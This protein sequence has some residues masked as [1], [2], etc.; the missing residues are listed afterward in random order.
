MKERTDFQPDL[1]FSLEDLVKEESPKDLTEDQVSDLMK[2]VYSKIEKEALSVYHSA[3]P[4]AL[5]AWALQNILR[6]SVADEAMSEVAHNLISPVIEWQASQAIDPVSKF[7]QKLVADGKPTHSIRQY[8]VSATKFVARKGRKRVYPEADIIEHFAWLR[9]KGYVKKTR[10]RKTG[11]VKWTEA[12]YTQASLR[13]E[14]VMLQEFF[15]F[16]HKDKKWSMPVARV[17]VPTAD[18]LNQPMLTHEQIEELI[19]STVIDRLPSNWIA[20]LAVSTL[21]GA[22]V[23]E[24]TDIQVHLDGND[25][26]VFIRTRKGGERREQPIPATLLPIFAIGIEPMSEWGLYYAFRSIAGKLGWDLPE[27]SGWHSVRRRVVTDIYTAT[28]AKDIPIAKFFRW[29]VGGIAQLPTYVKVPSK[30][31]DIDI[32]KQ[33]PFLEMWETVVPLLMELHPEYIRCDKAQTIYHTMKTGV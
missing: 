1:S 6:E 28:D 7:H 33:H 14:Y 25:S 19:L 13:R 32:L 5:R 17:K 22:R 23:S 29:R 20:R 2:K 9:E 18:E 27:G 21:Y 8:M 31:S 24:L 16:L 3:E 26:S 4:W 12:K 10:N 15:R 11:E 30:T